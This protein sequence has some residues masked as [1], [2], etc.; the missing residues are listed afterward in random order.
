M[1]SLPNLFF[2]WSLPSIIHQV[3][4]VQ[5]S[6]K[7]RKGFLIDSRK[8]WIWS[9]ICWYALYHSFLIPNCS[10][11]NPSLIILR[12]PLNS[13]FIKKQNTLHKQFFLL[14][15]PIWRRRVRLSIAM[16]CS[17][18]TLFCDATANSET[19]HKAECKAV[20]SSWLHWQSWNK[21]ELIRDFFNLWMKTFCKTL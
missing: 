4:H 18:P 21:A 8:L 5:V 10:N 12:A 13:L 11:S 7:I 9:C 16:T 19:T 20:L 15:P 6:L 3:S 1:P 17:F 2:M 14:K